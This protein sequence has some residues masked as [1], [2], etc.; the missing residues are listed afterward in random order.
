[1]QDLLIWIATG[2]GLGYSPWAPGTVGSLIGLPVAWWLFRLPLG[3]RL[4]VTLTLLVLAVPICHFASLWLGGGDLPQ[5]VLDEWV[6]LPIAV[7]AFSRYR[8]RI[9]LPLGYLLFRLF[10]ISKLSPVREIEGIGGGL[11]I[12]ADDAMAAL[13]AALTLILLVRLTRR[14]WQRDPEQ[15]S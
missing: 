14:Y 13:Y 5:I 4:A 15:S 7:L 9:I 2:F 3:T 8:R 1:M 6:A 11:G 10:D 12:V